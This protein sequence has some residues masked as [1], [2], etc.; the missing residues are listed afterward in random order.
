M[1]KPKFFGCAAGASGSVNKL[2]GAPL[3][4]TYNRNPKHSTKMKRKQIPPDIIHDLTGLVEFRVIARIYDGTRRKR[5]NLYLVEIRGISAKGISTGKTRRIKR[6]TPT[7]STCVLKIV[8]R[9]NRPPA[10]RRSLHVL[11]YLR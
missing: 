1:P 11:K 8:S 5:A 4:G 10:H 2:S 6:R 9:M 3:M 7:E